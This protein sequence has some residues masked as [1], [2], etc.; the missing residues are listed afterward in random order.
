MEK[1]LKKVKERLTLA[2]LVLSMDRLRAQ[3][4][5][6]TEHRAVEGYIDGTNIRLESKE[7]NSRVMKLRRGGTKVR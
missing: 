7:Y 2:Q 5:L 1:K 4:P 3:Q 6:F